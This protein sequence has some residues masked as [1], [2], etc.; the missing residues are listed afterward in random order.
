MH[1]V[2]QERSNIKQNDFTTARRAK[3]KVRAVPVLSNPTDLGLGQLP[4][5]KEPPPS[6]TGCTFREELVH[7][8]AG[9]QRTRVNIPSHS[10]FP[11]RS[12][13]GIS[14]L[15]FWVH[16]STFPTFPLFDSL[17][18]FHFTF[19][20][21]YGSSQVCLAGESLRGR[22][23]LSWPRSA[24]ASELSRALGGPRDAAQSLEGFDT[25][26]PSAQKGQE[27]LAL[28]ESFWGNA[29]EHT[30]TSKL[31]GFPLG[32]PFNP[33]KG[34]LRKYNHPLPVPIIQ[35]STI[36]GVWR[37]DCLAVGG[38]ESFMKVWCLP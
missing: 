20:D 31:V 3:A 7:L 4:V 12:F 16:S 32:L 38:T 28:V 10:W 37:A 5:R 23:G 1:N 34:S 33:Q 36:S 26:P 29:P 6:K 22:A 18:S 21:V 19:T 2:G 30:G 9:A 25:P 8:L 24:A 17:G 35:W 14:F 15:N 27:V 13:K 11:S